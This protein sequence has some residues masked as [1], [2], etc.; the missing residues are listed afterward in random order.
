MALQATT[1]DLAA[2]QSIWSAAFAEEAAY[3]SFVLAR[4]LACGTVLWNPDHRSC[5]TL[6]PI[7]YVLPGKSLAGFYVYGLA[8]HPQLKGRGFASALL[9][10]AALWAGKQTAAFL[11]LFPA[12]ARLNNFYSTRGYT[13][14]VR[15]PKALRVTSRPA[16]QNPSEVLAGNCRAEYSFCWPVDMLRFAYDECVLRGGF[17]T[18]GGLCYPCSEGWEIKSTVLPVAPQT[19]TETA[20]AMDFYGMLDLDRHPG[21]FTLPLD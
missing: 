9:Q 2:L 17:A 5:L 21:S 4:C 6:F 16:Q 19:I 11:M 3:T 8:T 15:V 18:G 1:K 14:T 7:N 20:L 10:E 13:A 12:S